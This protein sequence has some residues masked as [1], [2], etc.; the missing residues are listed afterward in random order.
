MELKV[1]VDGVQRVVCGV[2]DATTCQ[3]VVYA[4]AHATG[5][6]GRFT[7][8][9]KWRNNEH[10]LAPME[11]PLR[12]LTKWGEYSNDVQFVMRRSQADSKSSGSANQSNISKRQH[13][14]LHSFSPTNN[15]VHSNLSPQNKEIKKSL[16]FSGGRASSSSVNAS[17]PS[18]GASSNNTPPKVDPP[19]PP[20]SNMGRNRSRQD[21]PRGVVRGVP[22]R[23]RENEYS[24]EIGQPVVGSRTERPKH[25]PPYN[26]AVSRSSGRFPPSHLS[27]A[28]TG[29]PFSQSD[30]SPSS[31]RRHVSSLRTDHI[32]DHEMSHIQ[33]YDEHHTSSTNVCTSSGSNNNNNSNSN[34][35]QSSENIIDLNIKSPESAHSNRSNHNSENGKKSQN[36]ISISDRNQYLDHNL[37]TE[38]PKAKKNLL[39]EFDSENNIRPLDIK[40]HITRSSPSRSSQINENKHDPQVQDLMRLVSL[41]REKLDNQQ[42]ELAQFDA[43]IV[44][45]EGRLKEQEERLVALQ[46][47]VRRLEKAQLEHESELNQLE[48]HSLLEE[49]ELGRQQECTLRSELT[50]ARSQLANCESELLQYRQRIRQL[51]EDIAEERRRRAKQEEQVKK[52]REEQ[53]QTVQNQLANLQQQMKEKG[54]ELESQ[55]NTAEKLGEEL[56]QLE[57]TLSDKEQQIEKL[58]QEIREANLLSLSMTP[59]EE[60][61]HTLEGSFH[62]RPGS[63]RKIIGSPRQLENAVPTN[64]NP[65]GVWV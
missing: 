26:E 15:T 28:V 5:Q 32:I 56:K 25:P 38:T 57:S 49:A 58:S 31:K 39:S 2:T 17:I 22:Q 59:A 33:P 37:P 30:E 10:L 52:E 13:D 3:D 36:P 50:L 18:Q 48:Q 42:A 41:Q 62:N 6:T 1:W 53:E 29:S 20:M 45:W 61:K 21:V 24:Q 11:H 43:E 14:F 65:H 7:L 4:L 12:V 55:K 9:E 63:S 40:Q 35:N 60:I 44:Y 47:E 46:E 8:I 23:P 34:Y 19:L 54:K 64:K 51:L 27:L 16:T